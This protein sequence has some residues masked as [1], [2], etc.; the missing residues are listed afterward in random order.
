M[1]TISPHSLLTDSLKTVENNGVIAELFQI[2]SNLMK[3][4]TGSSSN[5][6]NA[7]LAGYFLGTNATLRERYMKLKPNEKFDSR[8]SNIP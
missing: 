4:K 5:D 8:F 7:F 3:E 1:K 2:W 6:F